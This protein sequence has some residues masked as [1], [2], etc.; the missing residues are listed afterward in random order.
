MKNSLVLLLASTTGLFAQQ[1]PQL[2]ALKWTEPVP[3]QVVGQIPPGWQIV[4]LKDQKITHGPFQ[5]PDGRW[6]TL[7][8]P[9]YVLQPMLDSGSL[10]LLE[11]G[12]D[13][14]DPS[15]N[16]RAGTLSNILY[17]EMEALR[18]S[19]R[20]C[21]RSWRSLLKS[22]LTPSRRTQAQA[23]GPPPQDPPPKRIHSK[24]KRR[25]FRARLPQHRPPPSHPPRFLWRRAAPRLFNPL[26]HRC[27]PRPEPLLPKAT[28]RLGTMGRKPSKNHLPPPV[29]H[30]AHPRPARRRPLKSLDTAAGALADGEP[31]RPGPSDSRSTRKKPL[32]FR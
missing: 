10:Y 5:L 15:G 12:F 20:T 24:S 8:T 27:P 23:P 1:Q 29:H 16:P 25:N 4:E 3:A 32:T 26:P 2:S 6:V 18:I 31:P 22:R 14:K 7:T 11:P 13:P 28:P 30:P 17:T 19:S 9:K 21:A